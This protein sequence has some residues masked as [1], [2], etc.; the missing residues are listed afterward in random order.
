MMVFVGRAILLGCFD[1]NVLGFGGCFTII[2]FILDICGI[3]PF[4]LIECDIFPCS[5][6]AGGSFPVVRG[7]P[8]LP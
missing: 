8:K 3:I 6:I 4:E 1:V 5:L 2:L 7:A